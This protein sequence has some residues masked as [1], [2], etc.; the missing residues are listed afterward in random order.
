[1]AAARGADVGIWTLPNLCKS[2]YYA[3][4]NKLFEYLAA[5]LPVLTANY[6]EAARIVERYEVGITFDA[7]SPESIAAAIDVL[8]HNPSL[9]TRMRANARAAL[10]D[11]R[12]SSEWNQL[13]SL[14]DGLRTG[15]PPVA[16][17]AAEADGPP[18]SSFVSPADP[19]AQ[20]VRERVP[21]EAR[22]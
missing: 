18:S 13:V 17:P 6:P 3:L 7:Y 5:G 4:P 2:F 15:W 16:S 21:T 14:Y 1:V 12:A 11:M 19:A 22:R 10:R 8:A 9:R 20:Q